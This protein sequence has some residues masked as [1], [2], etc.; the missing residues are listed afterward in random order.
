LTQRGFKD[1]DITHY[2]DMAGPLLTVLLFGFTF[3]FKGRIE[4]GNIYGLLVMGCIGLFFI[5]NLLS[6]K[7]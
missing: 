7:G 6:K 2:D 4:F 3:L 5:I 1:N